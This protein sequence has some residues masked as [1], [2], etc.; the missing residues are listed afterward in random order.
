MNRN[1]V[2]AKLAKGEPVFGPYIQ[3]FYT[4]GL[5]K[6]VAAAGADFAIFDSEHSGWTTEALRT[7]IAL[8]R[9]AGLVPIVNVPGERYEREGLFL[10]MGA[11]GIMVPHVA[12]AEQARALVAATRYPPLGRRGG[13]FGIAHDDFSTR[14][15]PAT[16]ADANDS[17]L[18]VAKLESRQAIENAEAILAVPGIDVALVTG[19]DLALDMGLGGEVSDPAIARAQQSVLEACARTGKVAGSPA[20]DTATGLKRLAEGYRFIQY[21]W[22][23]GLLQEGLAAGIR[24]LR[25]G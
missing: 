11:L 17:I 2:K 13:S 8:A 20:F 1:A 15:I 21:S 23:V 24:T 22:D 14:D 16:I 3:E 7:Q 18:I 12:S 9:G 5:A 19:F 10:D 4:A 6:I 25:G